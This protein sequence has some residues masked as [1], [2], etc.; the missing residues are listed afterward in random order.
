MPALTV[1]RFKF[2]DGTVLEN[3]SVRYDTWG[4]L[5]SRRDNAVVVGHTLTGNT[6]VSEWWGP[7][8]GPG[9]ALD[10]EQHFIVCAAVIGS[11][12]GDLSPLT[13]D[14]ASGKRYGSRF[15]DVTVRDTVR[16]HRILLDRLGVGRVA[17]AIGS[18]LGAMQVLEWAFYGD[19]VC[20]LV[21][22]AVG[23]R[24]SAWSIG[25]SESQRHCIYADPKWM[26]GDYDLADPPASGLAAARM[27]A[28][29]SYRSA[30]SY[31]ERFGRNTTRSDDSVFEM[32]SYLRYQGKKLVDR[33]DAS[34]YVSMTKQMNRHDISRGRGEYEDVLREIKQPA[35][36]VGITSD[37]LYPLA[38]QRELVEYLPNAVLEIIDS[39]HGHDSFLIELEEL[40]RRVLQWRKQVLPEEYCN[41]EALRWDAA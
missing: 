9:R 16:L 23:G 7:M 39:P 25:W 32:E 21:P 19:F 8:L 11:P 4:E 15:P 29:L 24:H 18:S 2:E 33:F 13:E 22:I 34:C 41:R 26:G 3:V 40:N 20:G 12:Y 27:V 5:N 6:D 1:P 17:L 31:Q 30:H 37:I 35:L 28:M 14:P 10:P 38:E 36:V